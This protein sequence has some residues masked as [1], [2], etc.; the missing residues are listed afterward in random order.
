MPVMQLARSEET[1]R[2]KTSVAR[3]LELLPSLEVLVWGG[4]RLLV[5]N[6]SHQEA[7]SPARHPTGVL[8]L[9][10][11]VLLIVVVGVRTLVHALG[12]LRFRSGVDVGRGQLKPMIQ[13][14]QHGLMGPHVEP[15]PEVLG[16]GGTN[17]RVRC[18][19]KHTSRGG[20][21]VL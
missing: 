6:G 2:L 21:R 11:L 9:L 10:K 4:G 20:R 17:G 1:W 5:S 18:R 8:H 3:A 13:G 14:L 12:E 19:Q 16:R 7:V 15:V